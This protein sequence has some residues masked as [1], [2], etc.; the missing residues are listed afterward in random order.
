[1]THQNDALK[2]ADP[3]PKKPL[4]GIRVIDLTRVLSGPFCTMILKNLG[5]EVIK[6]ERPQSGDDARF[7]TNDLRTRN[8]K[9]LTEIMNGVLMTGTTDWWME[10]LNEINIP[11]AKVNTIADLFHYDQLRERNMLV[12]VDGEESYK[13]AGNPVK[14]D[15]VP[16]DET[17]GHYPKL[18]EHNDLILED[19]LGYAKKDIEQFYQNGIVW[20]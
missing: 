17:A 1:M 14:I 9:A 15:G 13:I 18:G 3:L 2:I 16:E 11:C 6:V 19:L 20:K 12:A 7:K 5:A 8:V 10:R 4:E